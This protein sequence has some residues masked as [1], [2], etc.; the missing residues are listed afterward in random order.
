MDD[1]TF[2]R[3]FEACA[4]TPEQW[5]HRSHLKVAYLYLRRHGLVEASEKMPL[6]IKALNAAHNTPEGL[7][8]GYHHTITIAWLRIL[9][10][11]LQEYG[12]AE[13][14]DAFLDG[15]PQLLEKKIL[16]LFYSRDRIRSWEAKAQFI[17]PDLAPLPVS[18]S[19]QFIT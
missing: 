9:H 5:R 4:L 19:R 13:T 11:A 3:A 7:D 1:E 10:T 14:A 16:R 8:R 6:A 15:Q 2:L 17:E 12:P 18:K